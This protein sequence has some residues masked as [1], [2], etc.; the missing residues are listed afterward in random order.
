[1]T[2]NWRQTAIP[3]T[4]ANWRS[5]AIPVEEE[6]P[7]KLPVKWVGGKGGAVPMTPQEQLLSSTSVGRILDAFGQGAAEGWGTEPL[8][9]SD[10][11]VKALKDVGLFSQSG[12]NLYEPQRA[13]NEGLIRPLAAGVDSFFRLF[14]AAAR[15]VAS[16][17]GQAGV[18]MGLI[19]ETKP[20]YK[21]IGG[22]YDPETGITFGGTL[23]PT[24]YKSHD[25]ERFVA[26]VEEFINIG[27]IVAMGEPA[28]M[29]TGINTAKAQKS[30]QAIREV[31][32]PQ[33]KT[34][35][36][37][38]VPEAPGTN[39]IDLNT[40]LDALADERYALETS[41]ASVSDPLVKA[42][43]S[44]TSSSGVLGGGMTL[45]E[46]KAAVVWARA[47]GRDDIADAILARA[48]KQAA[49]SK[50]DKPGVAEDHPRY[51]E[52]EENLKKNSDETQQQLEELREVAGERKIIFSDKAPAQPI[53][54]KPIGISPEF[55]K[56]DGVTVDTAKIQ[57]L[58]D[59]YSAIEELSQANPGVAP[60]ATRGKVTWAE[61]EAAALDAG[62]PPEMLFKRAIG[63]AWNSTQLEG[64]RNL[65][66]QG[67]KELIEASRKARATGS[68][69][70]TMAAV[71]A[72]HKAALYNEAVTGAKTEAGRALNILK[73]HKQEMEE[74]DQL[75]KALDTLGGKAN[76]D[77]IMEALRKMDNAEPGQINKLVHDL[78][79][80]GAVD[81]ALEY[82]YN[83]M[84]SGPT[85]HMAN[86]IGNTVAQLW[87]VAETGVAG[88]IGA[89]RAA[90]G[91]KTALAG[92]RVYMGESGAKLYGMI[93]GL[94][95]GLKAAVNTLRTG[96]PSTV[97]KL[98]TKRLRKVTLPD[99]K[100]IEVP[101][102]NRKSIPDIK[103]EGKTIPFGS[104]VRLPGTALMMEDEI[105]QAMA[106]RAN[107][108][109]LAYRSASKKGL[110]GQDFADHVAKL[111][112]NPTKQMMEAARAEA[113]YVT[114]TK[115]LG[116]T[117]KQ[118]Q[119]LGERHPILKAWIAPFI[120][121]P[122]NLIKF[123]L[124]RTI[125]APMHKEI[126]DKLRGKHGAAV[127]DE[128]YAKIVLGTAITMGAYMAAASG[129]MTGSGPDD[130]TERA[131]WMLG[132]GNQ[133]Y[134]IKVG[135]YWVPYGRV[136]PIATLLGIS[137][138]FAYMQD[139]L[140]ADE[141][142][143]IATLIAYSASQNISNKTFLK[144]LTDATDAFINNPERFMQNYLEN[145]STRPVPAALGQYTRAEDPYLRDARTILE[146]YKTRLP[147]K[148][149]EVYPYR[150]IFG[151][152]ITR[153]SKLLPNLIR[154][155]P[156]AK[157]LYA[158]N[159]WPAKV[160]KKIRGVE[161]TRKQEDDYRRVAGRLVYMQL[162][163]LFSAPGW[164]QLPEGVRAEVA[165]SR[166]DQ[167]RE[168]ARTYIMWQYA[169][170]PDDI[171]RQAMKLK[172]KQLLGE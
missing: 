59:V 71:E 104:A 108:Q 124:E 2:D 101:V 163:T 20:G 170:T 97:S 54:P 84:L 41:G 33:A 100:T 133:P 4:T 149:T 31:V 44:A 70:D 102:E 60:L 136:E 34:P 58:K 81:M 10:E 106:Y 143:E 109:A 119:R 130:P 62:V 79:K 19:D 75:T 158:L 17:L 85:T 129:R 142:A 111:V 5:Q 32:E 162:K 57:E 156:V 123:P 78:S 137:A 118:L 164:S 49:R 155:D 167:A 171:M 140:T 48:E 77:E 90:M 9:L 126:Y 16:G 114:F 92:D 26:S 121:T 22:T 73:K 6:A 110:K 56:A 23:V 53:P 15:S 35:D 52:I 165:K 42:L 45:V 94:P 99:G 76:V 98:E 64:A 166:I 3:E 152:A 91:S 89:G 46:T 61:T 14:P 25:K 135:D 28:F 103:V 80:P 93:Q 145:L 172:R 8:G 161:L 13:F 117:G 68:D 36:P 30:T 146:A 120:R 131:A 55:V 47:N 168:T 67:A 43:H 65:L 86:I 147:G 40:K 105:F 159:A 51:K 12:P 21:Q 122:I 148:S 150:D 74:L 134:S 87:R 88:A 95:E 169:N 113:D 11:S 115:E 27:G 63:E 24:E 7:A 153:D 141:S 50:L 72:W 116:K 96:D 138:D 29:G 66:K 18:E 127:R 38:A 82:V 37:I 128:T 125:L 144:G 132:G 69:A 107:L 154:S 139:K 151:N 83:A 1:M 112:N 39:V 157:E 160:D